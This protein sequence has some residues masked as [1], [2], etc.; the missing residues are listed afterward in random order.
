MVR[1]DY[2]YS[3]LNPFSTASFIERTYYKV[4]GEKTPLDGAWYALLPIGL[5]LIFIALIIPWNDECILYF[6]KLPIIALSVFLLGMFIL[7]TITC[8]KAVKTKKQIEK[9]VEKKIETITMLEQYERENRNMIKKL[10]W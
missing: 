9:D 4:T 1:K 6:V 10:G 8:K 2:E 5:F 3:Y 7:S